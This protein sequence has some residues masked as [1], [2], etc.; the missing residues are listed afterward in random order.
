MGNLPYGGVPPA[1]SHSDTSN[2]AAEEIKPSVSRLQEVVL[3]ALHKSRFGETDE[4]LSW[5][6]GLPPN[7]LRPRRRELQLMG[8]IKDSG[9]RRRCKSGR[10]AV[11]WVLG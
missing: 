5:I 11:V 6:T 7:T 4:S 10:S 9:E 3:S 1:V 8:K 2:K